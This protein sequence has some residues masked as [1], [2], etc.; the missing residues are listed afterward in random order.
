MQVLHRLE[1]AEDANLLVG[2]DTA[3]DAAVYRLTDRCA[4][5]STL[6]FF[7]PIVDD[8]ATFGAVAAAN[9]LSDVYAMGGE[10]RL[11]MNIVCFPAALP[12]EVLGAIME[13]SSRKLREAGVL[14]VGG[15]SLEDREVKYGLAVSGFVDPAKMKTNAGARAGDV[16]VLTKPIGTGVVTTAL[17][18]GAL[19]DEAAAAAVESMTMLNRDAS[20]LMVELDASAATDV[21]GFGLIGHAVEMAEASK[22]TLSIEA[23]R[24]P[25]F[26]RVRELVGRRRLRPRTLD[27]N[28]RFFG[29]RV[30]FRDGLDRALADLLHDPQTSG[31][32]LIAAPPDRAAQLLGRLGAAGVGAAVIGEAVEAAEDAAVIVEP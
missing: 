8:P 27:E 29:E 20:R 9:A 19:D 13:G 5:I 4:L 12:V 11:A 16:L 14:L 10:P 3:D 25:L 31:G 6:D 24:V 23:S 32:L 28:R 17:K 15:H 1:H 30:R 18:Y 21:T 26:P 7:P 2:L 22:V